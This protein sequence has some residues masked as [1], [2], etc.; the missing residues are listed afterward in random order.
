M[1]FSV[2]SAIGFWLV[3][4][5]VAFGKNYS[6][7]IG[8]TKFAWMPDKNDPFR[9]H[10]WFFQYVFGCASGAILSGA[11]AERAQLI[12]YLF[13][14][15]W[16]ATCTYPFLVSW[17]WS[18]NGWLLK[19]GYVDYAGSGI[20]HLSGGTSTL[21]YLLFLG[22][23]MGRFK[24]ISGKGICSKSKVNTIPMHNQ[25]VGFFLSILNLKYF[26]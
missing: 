19:N 12:G 5:G 20:V 9:H 26:Y 18:G 21:I 3:G 14:S 16:T 10:D 25:P 1:K 2:I 23:R 17:A 8:T 24:W 15:L 7:V 11:I 6:S 13:Y 4:Y 22:P